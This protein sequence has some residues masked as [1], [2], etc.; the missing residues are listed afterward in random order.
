VSRL[1]AILTLPLAAILSSPVSAQG[2]PHGGSVEIVG[3][4]VTSGGYDAGTSQALETS[5]P[6]VKSTP[7]TLFSGEGRLRSAAGV[8]ARLGVYL[9][10]QFS[11]EGGLQFTKPTLRISLSNDF[12]QAPDTDAEE[13][14]TQ[15]VIDGTLLYHFARFSDGHASLF[16]AG[17]GGYLRQLDDGNERLTTGSQ[18]HGGGGMHYWFGS[19]NQ[20]LGLRVEGRLAVRNGSVSLETAD[21]HHLVPTLSVGL[22][23]LF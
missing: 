7:L 21:N 16:L 1:P 13:Q 4:F 8:E 9:S 23:Y 17:G 15:Y 5:N 22:G 20:R 11:V 6:S 14:I 19:G 18:F 2:V 3:A 12:E 10:P